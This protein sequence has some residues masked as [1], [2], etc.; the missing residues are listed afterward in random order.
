MDNSEVIK[1]FEAF[2]KENYFDWCGV[3]SDLIAYFTQAL[4]AKDKYYQ[5]LLKSKGIEL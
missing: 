1:E 2:G 3:S 4:E 5:D